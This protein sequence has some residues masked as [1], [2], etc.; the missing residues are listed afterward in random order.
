[1]DKLTETQKQIEAFKK[2]QNKDPKKDFSKELE[3]MLQDFHIIE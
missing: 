3:E 2:K 1:M